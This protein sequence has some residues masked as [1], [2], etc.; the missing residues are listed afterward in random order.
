MAHEYVGT[1]QVGNT[2]FMFWNDGGVYDVNGQQVGTYVPKDNTI[3]M[4]DSAGN[5]WA[6]LGQDGS[7]YVLT[8][9]DGTTTAAAS[10]KPNADFSGNYNIPETPTETPTTTP[11][12]PSPSTN[13]SGNTQQGS[14]TYG[15]TTYQMVSDGSVIQLWTGG[16][17]VGYATPGQDGFYNLYTMD[18]TPA[19]TVN[20]QTGA[21]MGA[22]GSPQ[23][24]VSAVNGESFAPPSGGVDTSQYKG[25]ITIT[26]PDGSTQTGYMTN[27]GRIV[28]DKGT[29]LL[30]YRQTG[31]YDYELLDLQGNVTGNYN[32]QSGQVTFADGSTGQANY[33]PTGIDVPPYGESEITTT[34]TR[35]ETMTTGIDWGS[36]VASALLPSITESA[37]A[38]PE[39]AKTAGTQAQEKYTNLMNQAMGPQAFQG[40]LNQLA[41]RGM[42][43]SSV[44]EGV[45]SRAGQGIMQDIGNKAFDAS[46]AGTQ[47]QMQVPGYLGSL[48]SSLGGTAGTTTGTQEETKKI[49]DPY[50]PFR[51]YV[52]LMNL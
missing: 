45:L 1:I 15:D 41:S 3:E 17:Q 10:W 42:L 16:N 12:Q 9:A 33:T 46:L 13:F 44:T 29:T 51:T 39:L 2:P 31:N 40:Y 19:C 18:N 11:T 22:D 52:S 27:D 25:T 49:K 5:L 32:T 30:Q 20:L 23:G 38:L 28:D 36:P 26:K 14:F 37:L 7:N 50:A 35:D 4:I 47:A 8:G 34:G 48:T 24:S 21:V 43:D 6:T